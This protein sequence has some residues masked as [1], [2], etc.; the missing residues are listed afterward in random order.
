[1]ESSVLDI[2][3]EEAE[4]NELVIKVDTKDLKV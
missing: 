1:M 3:N 2:V 4:A